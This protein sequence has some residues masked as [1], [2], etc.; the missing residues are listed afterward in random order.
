MYLLWVVY[1]DVGHKGDS[2]EIV[3][4]LL[5]VVLPQAAVIDFLDLHPLFL[6]HVVVL[7]QYFFQLLLL[8]HLTLGGEVGTVCGMV[9]NSLGGIFAK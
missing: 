6:C 9:V 1:V 7:G 2:V 3:S 8:D 4:K 5:D